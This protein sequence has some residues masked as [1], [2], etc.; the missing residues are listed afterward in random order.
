M[1]IVIV[2]IDKKNKWMQTPFIKINSIERLLN[3]E[4]IKE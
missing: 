3:E 1:P 2:K 4:R